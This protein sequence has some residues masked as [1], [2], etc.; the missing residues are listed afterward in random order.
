MSL[1]IVKQAGDVSPRLSP[2]SVQTIPQ[3]RSF[4]AM[5]YDVESDRVIL[6]GGRTSLNNQLGDTW[7]YDFDANE[8]TSMDPV[9]GPSPRAGHAMTYLPG[10]DRVLLYGGWL[11]SGPSYETWLYDYNTDTWTEVVPAASPTAYAAQAIAYDTGSGQAVLFGGAATGAGP[12]NETWVYNVTAETWSQMNPA[13]SPSPRER[14]RLVYVPSSQRMVLFGGYTPS[15][16][17]ETWTYDLANNTWEMMN[18]TTRPAA[19]HAHAMAYDSRADRVILSSG[20][21]V[22]AVRDTW[23][24]HLATDTWTEMNP[25]AE[26]GGRL[27]H[28]LAYDTDSDRVILFGGE[29][30]FV[31]GPVNNETWAYAYDANAWSPMTPPSSPRSLEASSGDGVVNL[32]WS[33]PSYDYGAPVAGYRIYRGTASGDLSLLTEADDTLSY[34]D[35]GVTF[36]VTYFYQVSAVSAAG[37]GPLS[38]EVSAAPDDE[39]DPTVAIDALDYGEALSVQVT[40]SASDD[41]AVEKVELGLDETDWTVASGTLSWSGT[42]TL[43]CGDN[44]IYARATDAAGNV[45]SATES[46]HLDCPPPRWPIVT[47]VALAGVGIAVAAAILIRRR[48][49]P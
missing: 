12:T 44:T 39:T 14:S 23:A 3:S 43:A 34:E 35:A 15:T 30:V 40:G 2:S 18:P 32:A 9:A 7:A 37:E 11:G 10:L 21:G 6:F 31:A 22:A 29:A 24:Y 27:G 49:R 28:R 8:W 25:S 5:A 16:D 20:D 17:D 46:V 19:R 42:L 36:G 1:A 47:V 4:H 26:P 45:A 13:T 38:P 48:G 41:V 33:A